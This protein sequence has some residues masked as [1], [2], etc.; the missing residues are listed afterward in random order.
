MP[1]HLPDF[2]DPWHL[3]S[4]GKEFSGRIELAR[5]PRLAG[6]LRRS[7]GHAD[8]ELDFGRDGE[9][10]IHITGRVQAHLVLE[11][12]RCLGRMNQVVDIDV[13]LA[14]IERQEEA[15]L[16]P[17]DVDPVLAEDG[18]IGLKDLIEDELLLA[19]PQVPR[20]APAQCGVESDSMKSGI[21]Q[22]ATLAD[23]SPFSVLEGLKSK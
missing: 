9:K 7:S 23:S 12:Q 20:H 16:L 3:A 11:C 13:N 2:V 19:I 14:V 10:R 21:E 18:Q 22:E 1:S 4:L 8:F 6:V 17:E 5:L 15:A